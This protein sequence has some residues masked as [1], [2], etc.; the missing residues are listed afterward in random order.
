MRLAPVT[1]ASKLK[2]R[3]F[4]SRSSILSKC[5]INRLTR[6]SPIWCSAIVEGSPL[7][8]EWTFG[9]AYRPKLLLSF[10]I[11]S[12]GNRLTTA[13]RSQERMGL[14]ATPCRS[15]VKSSCSTAKPLEVASNKGLLAAGELQRRPSRKERKR[16]VRLLLRN[17]KLKTNLQPRRGLKVKIKCVMR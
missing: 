9:L 2:E 12:L 11:F 10:L 7:I 5:A 6:A 15:K 4:R 17:R 1:Q 8:I 13:L 16:A 3:L 14:R